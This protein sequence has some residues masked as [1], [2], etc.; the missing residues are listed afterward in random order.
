ME[1]SQPCAAAPD[2]LVSSSRFAD[3]PLASVSAQFPLTPPG[4]TVPEH[5]ESPSSPE[6]RPFGL[7]WLVTMGVPTTPTSYRYCP[8]RQLAVDAVTGVPLPPR[9]AQEWT[10]IQQKD[11]DEGPSKDYGWE[12]VPDFTGWS[13]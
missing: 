10:T 6:T 9:L 11:G 8:T 4:F 1:K 2:H 13:S 3:D 12:T 7:R 5:S